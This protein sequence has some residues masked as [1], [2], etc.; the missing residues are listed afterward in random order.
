ML[1]SLRCS[2]CIRAL[3]AGHTGFA[4]SANTVQ[5]PPCA[6][7]RDNRVMANDS[8]DV[9]VIQLRDGAVFIVTLV[10]KRRSGACI[11]V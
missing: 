8:W 2:N 7:G 9:L 5:D 4:E 10:H 11:G 1:A 6:W 3:P